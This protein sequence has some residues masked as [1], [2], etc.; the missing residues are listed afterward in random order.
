MSKSW[1]S[2]QNQTVLEEPDSFRRKIHICQILFQSEENILRKNKKVLLWV[3]KDIMGLGRGTNYVQL[4]LFQ[5]DMD[6]SSSCIVVALGFVEV[7]FKTY[8]TKYFALRLKMFWVD[9]LLWLQLSPAQ[10]LVIFSSITFYSPTRVSF[11]LVPNSFSNVS[12]LVH[13]EE[14]LYR[15]RGPNKF[16]SFS[17][18]VTVQMVL[19]VLLLG[20]SADLR[21]GE[22]VVALGSPFSLQNTVTSGIVSST[23]RD[24]RELGLKDSDM[25]YIQTDAIINVR[26]SDSTATMHE[27]RMIFPHFFKPH[28]EILLPKEAHF[29]VPF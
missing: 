29:S 8:F 3:W 20:R 1:I 16:T 24:G 5:S 2:R 10:C 28:C 9:L 6:G 14:I 17:V 18:S 11:Q 22:F 4:G 7:F 19:P 26:D 23:Q 13:L 12:L 27:K 15:H 25:E 21:A